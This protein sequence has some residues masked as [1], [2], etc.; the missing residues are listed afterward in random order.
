[1]NLQT[2]LH[3]Q[4]PFNNNNPEIEINIEIDV[5]QTWR[6]PRMPKPFAVQLAAH[7]NVQLDAAFATELVN[8]NRMNDWDFELL[9]VI[10]RCDD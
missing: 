4:Q 1:M 9:E 10:V 8:L 7:E 2:P 5:I 3:E 6:V